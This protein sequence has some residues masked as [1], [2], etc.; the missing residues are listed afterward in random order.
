MD[1]NSGSVSLLEHLKRCLQELMAKAR[2][3]AEE[4]AEMHAIRQQIEAIE[5]L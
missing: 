5:A 3:S 2:L 4:E 1:E